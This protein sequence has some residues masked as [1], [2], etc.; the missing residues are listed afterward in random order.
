MYLSPLLAG[1][2]VHVEARLLIVLLQL[3]VII[4][5][6]RVFAVLFRK[7]GQ[8]AVVGEIAGGLILGPSVLGR[9]ADLPYVGVAWNTVFDPSVGPVFQ[10]ISQLGLIFLLFLIG[11]EFDFTHLR[12]HSRAAMSISVMGIMLPFFIGLALAKWIHPHLERPVDPRGFALFMGTAMSITAI[13]ILGRMMMEMNITRTR[14]GAVTIVAAAIDDAFGWII[15]AAVSAMVRA[16]FH[17]VQSLKMFALT[18]AF[19]LVMML[20]VRPVLKAW[21]RWVMRSGQGLGLNALAILFAV[22]FLCAIVTNLIG[23]FSIFGAFVLGSVLSDEH[24]FRQA[25]S[26]QLRSFV[27]VFFLPI[28][29]TYTGLRTDIGTLH[30][31]LMWSL[32]LLVSVGAIAGKF[33]GCALAARMGGMPWRESGCVGVMMNTRA[34]MELIVINVGYDLGVIPRSVF[35]ML[36]L[37]ALVT[38]VMTTPILMRLMR[39]TELERLVEESG[40]RRP[41]SAAAVAAAAVG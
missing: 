33:G 40:F 27:T 20:V 7:M 18:V 29:F 13:P 31:P 26:R 2:D 37:M 41:R 9:M 10:I 8:P 4:L 16:N 21:I 32:A 39:G 17:L 19:A 25:V 35:C 28:F 38:T 6:A 24:E 14:L 36:V 15:L 22:I 34:L 12:S 11:L 1:A 3:A 30:G 23:I 5:V